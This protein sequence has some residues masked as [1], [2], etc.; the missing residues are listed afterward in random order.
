MSKIII[1]FNPIISLFTLT[2]VTQV[3]QAKNFASQFVLSDN[4]INVDFFQ[5]VNLPEIEPSSPSSS[6]SP[7]QTP[8]PTLPPANLLSFTYQLSKFKELPADL[9]LFIVT[10]G[11]K[12]IFTADANLADGL[13]HQVLLD[14]SVLAPDQLGQTPVFYQNSYL[15][16]FELILGGLA[17]VSQPA[18]IPSVSISPTKII[19][20]SAIRERDQSLT[21]IF[22]LQETVR[23]QH[24]YKLSC[25]DAQGA[26]PDSVWLI[27][28]D[29]FLWSTLSFLGAWSNQKNE[30]IFHL[31]QFDCAGQVQFI[32]ERGD[33]SEPVSIIAVEN[34]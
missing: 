17:F 26:K 32:N 24:F 7:N 18:P 33:I 12:V 31:A 29:N 2:L 5:I 4:S 27:K 14:I 1:F 16:D 9:P 19:N 21:V 13:E 25:L 22:T 11:Q 30:L 3:V 28:N 6:P 23:E 20:P 8:A 34:L 15:D 10:L